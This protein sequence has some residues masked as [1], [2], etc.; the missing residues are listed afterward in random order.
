VEKKKKLIERA[1][2]FDWKK[3]SEQYLE[4]YHSL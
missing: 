3:A 1:K 2:M 4:L